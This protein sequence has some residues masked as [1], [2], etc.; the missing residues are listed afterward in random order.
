VK[1]VYKF[2]YTQNFSLVKKH[3]S[4]F[5][6]SSLGRTFLYPLSLQQ[7]VTE[8]IWLLWCIYR[9]GKPQDR[10]GARGMCRKAEKT[11]ER[12]GVNPRSSSWI[13][14]R[15]GGWAP[16]SLV[17]PSPHCLATGTPPPHQVG[18]QWK[19]VWKVHNNAPLP[20]GKIKNAPSW[21]GS[22]L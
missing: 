10:E 17:S 15:G 20:V 4:S 14:G 8:F 7:L 16:T 1:Q 5:D 21:P 22:T 11:D 12:I 6:V 19:I 18:R 13:E 3:Y 2:I 9:V